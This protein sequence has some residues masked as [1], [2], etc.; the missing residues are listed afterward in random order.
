MVRHHLIILLSAKC[1][2]K[3]KLA[4]TKRSKPSRV[5]LR[6]KRKESGQ[7]RNLDRCVLVCRCQFG[8]LQGAGALQSSIAL[9]T[10]A[11]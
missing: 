6:C 5:P 9:L 1:L 10:E 3:A 7:V 8:N 4:S 2:G 11:R